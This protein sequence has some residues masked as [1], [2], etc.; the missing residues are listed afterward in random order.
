MA[1]LQVLGTDKAL[2]LNNYN[3]LGLVQNFNWAPNF[4]AQDV[5]ELGRTTR[6][7][8]LMELETSG[9]FE[10]ASSGNL[11]GLIARMKIKQNLGQFDGFD[12]APTASGTMVNAYSYTQDDLANL[13][14]D[15]LL[16]EK[17]EQTNFNRSTYLACCYPTTFTGRVQ[18]NGMAMDSVNWAGLFVVGFPSP[19]HDARAVPA[20]KATAT[21][22]TLPAPYTSTDWDVAYVT[23][24]GRPL[25]NVASDPVKISSFAGS[26]I[27]ISGTTVG[28]GVVSMALVYKKVPNTNWAT[29]HTPDTVGEVGVDAVYGIRGYQAN[30]YIAPANVAT[31][32]GSEQWL[33]VQSID[34]T[35][36]LRMESLRQIALNTQGTSIYHRAVTFPLAMSLNA[37]V[38]EAD[39]QDWKQVLNKTFTGGNWQDNV[40]EFAPQYVK[41]SFAIVIEYFT[42]DGTKIQR[43]VFDD[44][45]VDGMG[46]RIAVGGRGEISWTFRGSQMTLTGYDI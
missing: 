20:L 37:T 23:V 39:W 7:E 35:I 9:S 34:Y 38:N 41:P 14:F 40:Y 13:K 17:T 29:V 26:T 11:A 12:Y 46:S 28:D 5:N 25:R 32:V 30:V 8:T 4:N 2:R 33:K 43:L 6:L 3:T 16:H 27:T 42:K 31:P 36:D 18:A 45:R 21:T 24:D 44:M 15:I 19:Y 22:L 10:L 1:T